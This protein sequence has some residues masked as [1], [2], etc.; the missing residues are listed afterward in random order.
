LGVSISDENWEEDWKLV[1]GRFVTCSPLGKVAER[2]EID[3]LCWPQVR[4]VFQPVV[5]DLRVGSVIRQHYADDRAIHALF[6]VEH[7]HRALAP[8]LERVGRNARLWDIPDRELAEFEVARDQAGRRL[9]RV[10]E[11]LRGARSGYDQIDV[12]PELNGFGDNDVF[13]EN[14]RRS[15]WSLCPP[16]GLHELTAFSLPLGRNPA[17]ADLW[18]FVAFS[19]HDGWIEQSPLAIHDPTDGEL[20][21][22]FPTSEDVTTGM[23]DG[24]LLDALERMEPWRRNAL[25]EQVVFDTS[26]VPRLGSKINDPYQTLVPNTSC[27]SCH[28]MTNL[29]FNFHNFSY[30]EDQGISVA[31]RVRNDVVRDVALAK[32][33]WN[34]TA[35]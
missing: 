31:P 6:R 20:L 35:R 9:L 23:G 29:N 11:S 33:I 19:G 1:S 26:E 30:F 34:R 27:S 10:L 18:S 4:L 24:E 22:A 25:Q 32:Q 16:E 15:L 13:F 7:D 14:L 8:V 21:Y 17:S 28:R 12:R 5:E 3:R 2:S